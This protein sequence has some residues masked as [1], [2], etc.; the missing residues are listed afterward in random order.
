MSAGINV[1]TEY[2]GWEPIVAFLCLMAVA[3]PALTKALKLDDTISGYENAAAQ[4]KVIEGKL[5]RAANIWSN[6]PLVEFEG[7]VRSALD[8]LDELGQKSLTPPEW[9]FK[10]VQIKV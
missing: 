4:F 7:E 10:A 8:E 6:K 2:E 3:S 1:Q 9:C 5:R